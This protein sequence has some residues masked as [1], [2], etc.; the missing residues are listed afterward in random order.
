M[1][2]PPPPPEPPTTQPAAESTIASE[3]GR[4]TLNFIIVLPSVAGGTTFLSHVLAR[5][6]GRHPS[7]AADYHT[8][9]EPLNSMKIDDIVGHRRVGLGS[10]F[11]EG[12][13]FAHRRIAPSTARRAPNFAL[14]R[15]PKLC[16]VACAQTLPCGANPIL[17]L[18]REPK[19][20]PVACAQSQPVGRHSIRCP[21]AP[22]QPERRADLHPRDKNFKERTSL[23]G[24][25]NQELH[26]RQRIQ[27]TART[28][29]RRALSRTV[30][31]RLR[32]TVAWAAPSCRQRTLGQRGK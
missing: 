19:R 22:G 28:C 25:D 8:R 12:V 32:V 17:A 11:D 24:S 7:A 30:A 20:C 14:W 3:N 1:T 13:P 9:F 10:Q 27:G 16:P 23:P 2:A 5:G 18:W 21:L 15:V 4:I 31:P 6:G 29:T 26:S